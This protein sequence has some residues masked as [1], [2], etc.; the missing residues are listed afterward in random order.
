MPRTFRIWEKKRG[1]RRTGSKFWGGLGEGL[2]FAALFFVGTIA[3]T[4][5]V[6]TYA[7]GPA[8][9]SEFG[10]GFWLTVLVLSSC[11]LIGGGGFLITMLQFG[12][13]AERRSDMAQRAPRIDL[14]AEAP[15]GA[16][17]PAVPGDGNLTNSPGVRLSFRLPSEQTPF[18]RLAASMGFAVIWSGITAVLVVLAVGSFREG[19]P[20]WFLAVVAAAFVLVAGWAIYYFVRQLAILTGIGPTG[21]EISAHPFYPGG[22]YQVFVSQSGRLRMRILEL[23]LVCEEEATYHQ[24][25][26]VRTDRARVFAQQI[27]CQRNFDIRPGSPLEQECQI[28]IPAGAMHSFKSN[29]NAV[30]WK[31]VVRGHSRGWPRFERSF[32]VVVYPPVCVPQESA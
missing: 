4:A 30:Q 14:L 13:S 16:D 17:Y 19:R 12:A 22:K 3:L 5:L 32:P 28:E 1:Q 27:F 26:D 21:V 29:S 9:G 6:T 24:G 15:K 2:F 25:T 31:L 11:V 20:E 7:A 10:V 23:V 8:G 18:W